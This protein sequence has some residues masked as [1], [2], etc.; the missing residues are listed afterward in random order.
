MAA[1]TV[2]YL[3]GFLDTFLPVL[4]VFKLQISFQEKMVLLAMLAASYPVC[5]IAV[6]RIYYI[7]VLFHKKYDRSWICGRFGSLC[8]LR[9]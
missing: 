2:S 6:L 8:R 9:S 5:A 3:Q 7:Y 4:V 1:F